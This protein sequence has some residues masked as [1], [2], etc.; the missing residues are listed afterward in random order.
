MKTNKVS[1]QID[2]GKLYRLNAKGEHWFWRYG[3]WLR[4]WTDTEF[5]AGHISQKEA[6]KQFPEAFKTKLP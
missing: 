4:S 6:R 2:N 5:S 1:Y 3:E